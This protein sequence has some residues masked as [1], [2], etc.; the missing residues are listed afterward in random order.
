MADS[1]IVETPFMLGNVPEYHKDELM[2]TYLT[3]VAANNGFSSV[4]DFLKYT[5]CSDKDRRKFYNRI[6][7]DFDC[8]KRETDCLEFQDNYNW[9]ISGTLFKGI[10]PLQSQKD[11]QNRLKEYFNDKFGRMTPGVAKTITSLRLCPECMKEE[12]ED[13]Y[14]HTVHQMPYVTYCNKHDCRLMQVKASKGKIVE[15]PYLTEPTPFPMERYLSDFS[16]DLFESDPQCNGYDLKKLLR[17]KIGNTFTL[18]HINHNRDDVK[19]ELLPYMNAVSMKNIIEDNGS[20]PSFSQFILFLAYYFNSVEEL[21][22]ELNAERIAESLFMEKCRGRF[23]LL[24]EYRS[25]AVHVRCLNCGAVF[26]ISPWAVINGNA[27]CYE[28]VA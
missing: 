8:M 12:G 26:F 28:C 16:T 19:S 27:R 23:E 10:A 15:E 7:L 25:D 2:Y 5:V 24:G 14:Y 9:L 6:Y 13:W 1:I 20:L 21:Q 17:H 22:E 4:D 3:R 11:S 18:Y